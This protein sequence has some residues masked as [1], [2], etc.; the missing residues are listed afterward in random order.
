M[1]VGIVGSEGRKF[2]AQGKRD[3]INIISSI[4]LPGDV[5]I[6]GHCHLGG[7]DIW[8]EEFADSQG[9]EKRI[10]APKRLSWQYYKA[11]NIQ[12]AEASDVVHVIV[13]DKLPADYRGMTFLLC[14]HCRT[15][16]HVKSGACW[17]ARRAISLGK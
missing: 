17:T 12:I 10:F 14:Y 16:G 7:V 4:L 5:L 1:N 6:S 8:A 11:R 3:A 15:E 13:V 9:R 2:T